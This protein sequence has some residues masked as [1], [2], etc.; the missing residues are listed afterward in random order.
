MKTA[1][2]TQTQTI[3]KTNQKGQLVIP[4]EFR[5]F[6]GINSEVLLSVVLRGC[7]VF[8]SPVS[9]VITKARIEPSY[10]AILEKTRGAWRGDDW[11][12]TRKK[13]RKIEL[14]ASKNRKQ[15]W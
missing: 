10:S 3:T 14:Q 1:T 4:K 7:G 6:L 15:V 5:D 12:Q 8:I 2:I 9:E 13:R 11:P